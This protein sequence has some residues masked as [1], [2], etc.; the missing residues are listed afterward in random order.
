LQTGYQPSTASSPFLAAPLQLQHWLQ[1]IGKFGAKPDC[2]LILPLLHFRVSP[3][4]HSIFDPLVQFFDPNNAKTN[5]GS[6]KF[7]GT[8]SA[9]L[10]LPIGCMKFLF[11]KEFVTIFGLG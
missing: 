1:K 9:C 4:Y 3:T 11:P 2:L 6:K 8:L 5:W 10:G 7:K